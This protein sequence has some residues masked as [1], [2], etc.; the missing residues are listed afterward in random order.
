MPISITNDHNI[1]VS[2]VMPLDIND[3]NL[4][5]PTKM[6]GMVKVSPKIEIQFSLKILEP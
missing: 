6:L 1:Q 2:G 4:T 5:A 3:F